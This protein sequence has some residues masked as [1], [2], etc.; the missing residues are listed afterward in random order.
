MRTPTSQGGMKTAG[1]A[2]VVWEVGMANVKNEEEFVVL[3]T[4]EKRCTCGIVSGVEFGVCSVV[5]SSVG[6][7][8]LKR[9]EAVVS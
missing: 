5:I 6:G 8:S 9:S 2:P 4:E 1:N 7:K 3:I